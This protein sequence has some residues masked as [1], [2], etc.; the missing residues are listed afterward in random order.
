M[1]IILEKKDDY[2]PTGRYI[3]AYAILVLDEDKKGFTVIK[4]RRMNNANEHY[5]ISFLTTIIKACYV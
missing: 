4:H 5:H 3:S 2:I 1:V